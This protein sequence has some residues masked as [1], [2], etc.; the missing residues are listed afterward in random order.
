MNSSGDLFSKVG[1]FFKNS[2]FKN[3]LN[4]LQMEN[5]RKLVFR[6]IKLK[7]KSVNFV[8]ITPFYVNYN[9]IYECFRNCMFVK[10]YTISEKLQHIQL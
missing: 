2:N 5:L 10:N 4:D 9:L 6:H 3:I 7:L 1:R 8:L